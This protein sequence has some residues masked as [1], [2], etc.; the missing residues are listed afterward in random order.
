[1]IRRLVRRDDSLRG[2]AGEA[3]FVPPWTWDGPG[4][5]KYLVYALR[6]LRQLPP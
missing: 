5:R 1:L 2:Q 6:W 3:V 4:A